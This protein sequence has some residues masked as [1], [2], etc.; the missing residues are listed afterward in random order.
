VTGPFTPPTDSTR[1]VPPNRA[2]PQSL[3]RTLAVW[4]LLIVLFVAIYNI[5]GTAPPRASAPRASAPEVG[6]TL[7]YLVPVFTYG[8]LLLLMVLIRRRLP[9]KYRTGELREIEAPK[10]EEPKPE[11]NPA[12]IALSFVGTDGSRPVRLAVDDAGLHWFAEARLI[13]PAL[14]LNVA[15]T[16]LESIQ[17]ARVSG[18][19]L[20]W[21]LVLIFA[22]ALIYSV[23]PIYAGVGALLG[24]GLLLLQRRGSRGMVYF[25]TTTHV[26][27][28]QS[29]ELELSAQDA[30]MG[31]ARARCPRAVAKPAAAP[32][33]STWFLLLVEPFTLLFKAFKDD[34]A[35]R[36]EL[37]RQ[38]VTLSSADSEEAQAGVVQVKL[39]SLWRG[40]LGGVGPISTGLGL[41]IAAASAWAFI[42]GWF[43][44]W[45]VGLILLSKS[46]RAFARFSGMRLQR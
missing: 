34:E 13:Q 2:R 45:L 27:S 10:A 31:A 5:L 36:A 25:S 11:E 6:S 4:A 22:S 15:W 7:G 1:V 42:S 40:L 19:L 44:S 28:F 21:G 16:E 39:F 46:M 32:T 23:W 14:E 30:L 3:R 41:S 37:L 35:V 43:A 33:K 8:A 29:P 26:L 12:P 38:G 20:V 9:S 17:T 24:V 18:P